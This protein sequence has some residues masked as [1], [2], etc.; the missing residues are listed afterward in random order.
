MNRYNQISRASEESLLLQGHFRIAVL[1]DVLLRVEFS[2][3]GKFEDRTTQWVLNRT[4]PVVDF[5][6]EAGRVVTDRIELT[7]DP[8]ASELTKESFTLTYLETGREFGPDDFGEGNFG[9]PI[10]TF[11]NCD[12]DFN[13]SEGRRMELSDGFFSKNGVTLLDDTSSLVFAENGLPE[14]RGAGTGYRDFYLLAY[15]SDYERAFREIFELTGKPSML[16]RWALGLWWS[17]WF[18]YRDDD[19]LRIADEF[20]QHGAPLSAMVVDMDWH[21]VKNPHH[22]G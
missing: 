6:T 22:N 4:F 15:G 11:D 9:G 17:R 7:F 16:P 8:Q 18:K 2:P 5:K 1:S 20:K 3:E 10:R 21:I 13:V 14:P 19:L 12:G